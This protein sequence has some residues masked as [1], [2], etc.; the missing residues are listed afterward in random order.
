MGNPILNFLMITL[1]YV[2][3]FAQSNS[4]QDSL[5]PLQI[6]NKWYYSASSN[7][8]GFYYGCIK[9]ITAELSNGFRE[10]TC[11]Y[12]YHHDS[13]IVKKEYQGLFNGKLYYGTKP[14]MS[15]QVIY[16]SGL[17]KDS[18]LDMWT[19]QYLIPYQIFNLVGTA[20]KNIDGYKTMSES[21]I[22]F[23]GIGICNWTYHTSVN[24]PE[25]QYTIK[26]S[27]SLI[28]MYRNG[29]VLGDTVITIPPEDIVDIPME[30]GTI[31]SYIISTGGSVQKTIAAEIDNGMKQ[32]N[33]VYSYPGYT[34]TKTEFW[35]KDKYTF[36]ISSSASLDSGFILYNT[37]L[38]GYLGYT[39]GGKNSYL[40]WG[41]TEEYQGIS[42]KYQ[43]DLTYINGS[44]YYTYTSDKLGPLEIISPKGTEK[45]YDINVGVPSDKTDGI[46]KEY[47]L[48]QNYPNPFNPTTTIEY[49]I[50][51][52]S[53]VT[54]KVYDI[55]GRE[56]AALVN[57]EKPAG[58][59]QVTFNGS[60]LASGVYFYRIEAGGFSVSKKLLLLK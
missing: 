52:L 1:V 53:L 46:I 31:F 25:F 33:C 11:K 42:Y 18:S 9:E 10:F 49:S 12:L 2:S 4:E 13:I 34:E 16:Y 37:L 5:F 17:T 58:R 29:E 36:S 41:G 21:N 14:E 22:V 32:V 56:V 55:L 48:L 51:S 38:R 59:Y 50:P 54:L 35:Y 39:V 24:T 23:P 15:I 44:R 45:L 3:G 20:Q 27:M 7:E 40:S 43:V 47:S 30:I 6:G 19:Y 8:G 57:D 26:D 60:G 28:G